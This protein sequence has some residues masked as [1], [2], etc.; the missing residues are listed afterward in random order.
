MRF[1]ARQTID[2]LHV[3]FAWR[4]NPAVRLPSGAGCAGRHRTWQ[5]TILN[6]TIS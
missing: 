6:R 5:G 3:A 4:I 1:P 2:L